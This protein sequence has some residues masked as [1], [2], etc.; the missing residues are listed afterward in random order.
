MEVGMT[1]NMTRRSAVREFQASRARL[2]DLRHDAPALDPVEEASRESF[3]ASDP[4]AWIGIRIGA[5]PA[6][7]DDAPARAPAA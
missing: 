1:R 4:P 7:Q 5:H 6:P 2:R 3:P